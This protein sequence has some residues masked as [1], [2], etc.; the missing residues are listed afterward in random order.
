MSMPLHPPIHSS[1][2]RLKG[3]IDRDE[4]NNNHCRAV[5]QGSEKIMTPWPCLS[6]CRF[7]VGLWDAALL[8]ECCPIYKANCQCGVLQRDPELVGV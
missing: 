8:Q 2:A 1:L 5:W 3:C 4:E 6:D 7:A